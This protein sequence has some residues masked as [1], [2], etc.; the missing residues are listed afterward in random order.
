M[1]LFMLV[2]DS[3]VLQWR[4]FLFQSTDAAEACVDVS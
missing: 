2:M 1:S 4:F 3:R